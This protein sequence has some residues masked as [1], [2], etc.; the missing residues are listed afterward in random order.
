[1]KRKDRKNLRVVQP[2]EDPSQVVDHV[3]TDL[4]E[5]DEAML[6]LEEKI[7]KHRRWFRIKASVAAI[8]IITVV[9]GSYLMITRHTYTVAKTVK[10]VEDSSYHNSSYIQFGDGVI[11]YSKDGVVFLDKN[12]KEK[13]NQPS[14]M[15]SPT[16]AAGDKA[17]VIADNGGNDMLVFEEK[18]LK[19]EI[20]TTLPIE[21]AVVSRQGIVA[22]ILKDETTPRVVCY[23]AT[24]NLLV[25]HKTTLNNSGY[26]VGLAISED[27]YTLMVSYLKLSGTQSNSRIVYY[28]FGANGQE[29][30][31]YEVF[32]EEYEN[33]VIP[34]CFFV[35]NETSVAVGS[36]GIRFYH[37]KSIPKQGEAV[38]VSEKI[39]SVF[40][41]DQYVGILLKKDGKEGYELRVY[42]VHGKQVL[43]ADVE[44]D[45]GHIAMSGKKV[46]MYDNNRLCVIGLNG[47][48]RFEGELE[49][50][51]LEIF[52]V[53]GIN[54]YLMMNANGMKTVR[55][56]K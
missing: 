47:I 6:E 20:Q 52:P 33:T 21:R 18:G 3:I 34:E 49:D 43:K 41:K 17:V 1:M 10:S 38:Q 54:K 25:E 24:G 9:T 32:S 12:G 39:Q 51:I 37:G 36:D 16:A 56:V 42:T 29:E 8:L 4:H 7:R 14:Q 13:W 48:K 19:G 28:N 31:D 35:G 44:K 40:Q 46:L 50:T 23:D 30:N 53:F 5:T 55:F 11:K 45:Y 15:A 26:P 27:G 2:G 22:A